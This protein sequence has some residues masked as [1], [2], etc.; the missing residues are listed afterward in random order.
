[1]FHDIILTALEH[2][3][4]NRKVGLH[5]LLILGLVLGLLISVATAI[6]LW[7]A[8]NQIASIASDLFN[9]AESIASAQ[10]VRTIL[11]D[12]RRQ[13]MLNSRPTSAE[14][15]QLLSNSERKLAEG[16]RFVEQFISSPEE[17]ELVREMK[18][19]AEKY[20]DRD[21][22]LILQGYSP[23]RAY[24]R[25]VTAF[26]SA[27]DAIQRVIEFNIKEAYAREVDAFAR[28]AGFKRTTIVL[29]IGVVALV[30]A[31]LFAFYRLI[32]G[33]LMHLRTQLGKYP[34]VPA[35]AI[36]FRD[37]TVRE[38]DETSEAFHE[39]I[40]RLEKLNE[41]KLTILA[42]IAHDLRN[43]LGA[44]KMSL[45]LLGEEGSD[46]SEAERRE[47]VALVDRQ[48]NQLRRLVDD[49][50]STSQTQVGPMQLRTHLVD[51]RDPIHDVGTL[52]RATTTKH[53]IRLNL[54][55]QPVFVEIDGVRMGQVL[56]NL[57]TNAIKYS[58]DGGIVELSLRQRESTAILTV[59]D[60]GIGIGPEDLPFIFEPFR[61]SAAS[62]KV[63]GGIG[64]GLAASRRIV[65]A[66]H[67]RITVRSEPR[68]GSTFVLELPVAQPKEI[69][70][71]SASSKPIS[72]SVSYET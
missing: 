19:E 56:N 3:V 40:V 12:Y 58:P 57:I 64:L 5:S 67:G 20:L 53:E 71:Q 62:R 37:E 36:E 43:P 65:E 48:V 70:H 28:S 26:E 11:S 66:H 46:L 60:Q 35:S 41:Q 47:L 68:S 18:L 21:R 61:R 69:D 1:M 59:S 30:S 27:A 63:A 10:R 33:P 8:S 39:L 31:I 50:L 25:S 55:A 42:A 9:S 54:P 14:R 49:I 23:A 13:T 44:I 24:S 22:V 17:I 2:T 15:L 72:P 51:L 34:A 4:R 52:F 6:N 45:D 16:I 7:T 29:I 38:I 32:Y